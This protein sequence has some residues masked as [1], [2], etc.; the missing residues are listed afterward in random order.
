M[1][2]IVV[3]GATGYTGKQ[4]CEKLLELGANSDIRLILA[5]R[6]RIELERNSMALGQRF[7]QAVDIQALEMTDRNALRQV[8]DGSSVIVNCAAPYSITGPPMLATAVAVK[9]HLIDAAGEPGYIEHCNGRA[10]AIKEAGIA[11]VNGVATD[12][13]IADLAVE[14]AAKKWEAVQSVHLLYLY[15]NLEMSNGMRE[16]TLESLKQ[17]TRVYKERAMVVVPTGSKQRKFTWDGGSA[18]GL[19]TPG[20]EGILLP[21]HVSGVRNVTVYRVLEGKQKMAISMVGG[22]LGVMGMMAVKKWAAEKVHMSGSDTSQY[23]VIIELEGVKSKRFAVIQGTGVYATTASL[24][25]H[26]TMKLV[27]DGPRQKGVISPAQAFQA[28]WLL[29]AAGIEVQVADGA[30]AV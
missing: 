2:K 8:C 15:K 12:P 14:V 19:N 22:P 11:V 25:A 28:D 17:P 9:A 4:V 13:G 7:K 5:G 26:A 21:R 24:L 3:L 30:P 18:S 10:T 6:Y 16:S 23:A 20:G 1:K 29:G 27:T